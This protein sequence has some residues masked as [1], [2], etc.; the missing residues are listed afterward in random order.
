[1][2]PIT[3]SLKW[4]CCECGV[5]NQPREVHCD[6]CGKQRWEQL[7]ITLEGASAIVRRMILERDV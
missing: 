1:M 7:G 5:A 4:I 6:S 3:E 2:K